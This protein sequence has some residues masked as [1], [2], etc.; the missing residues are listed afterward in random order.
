HLNLAFN[1]LPAFFMRYLFIISGLLLLAF[2]SSAQDV[3]LQT[4]G[5]EVKGKVVLITPERVG[6]IGEG[7]GLS[8]TLQ[9]AHS[10]VF[11]IRYANGTKEVLNNPASAPAVPALSQE[12]AYSRGRLDARKYF[13]PKGA[14]WGTYAA[15]VAGVGYGGLITGVAIG[16]TKPKAHNFVVPEAALLQDPNYVAGYRRQAQNKKIGSAAGGFGAG[17]GTFLVLQVIVVVAVLSAL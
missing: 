11:L 9:L 16:A 17:L 1:D 4:N 10:A 12:E 2:R 14:F 7:T 6:Y 13:K 8:D 5:E 15:T 3:I